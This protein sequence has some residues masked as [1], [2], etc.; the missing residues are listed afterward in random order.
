MK[1][2][3]ISFVVAMGRHTRAMGK[4]N[5]LLWKIPEDQKFF[6]DVTMGHPMIMGRKTFDS[7][8][9]VLPG[10]TN[11]VITRNKNWSHKGVVVVPSIEE[12][13]R[14][15]E[16]LD[17]EEIT[18]IGGAQIF[19]LSLPYVT[20]LYLTLVDDDVEG[21]TYFPQ[22]SLEDFEKV[23]KKSGEYEGLTYD[24]YTFDK[25]S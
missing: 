9:R 8:G 21:D 13:F 18:V 2:P 23:D 22:M 1:K 4:D 19:E 16:S 12:A 5:D 11:I 15:G 17:K 20:R 10:R 7:I 25:I 24:I 14:I 6:K 3:Y